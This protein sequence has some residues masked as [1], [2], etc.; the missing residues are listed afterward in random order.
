MSGKQRIIVIGWDGAT[1]DYIDP[2]LAIGD[3]PHL[4]GL[5]ERGARAT[6]RSTVPPFTNVA[7]PALVTGRRPDHTGIFG[8]ARRKAGSYERLPTNLMEY[9]GVP[10]WH[11]L[12]R[13]GYRAGVLNVPMTYPAAALDGYLVSGFDSPTET[14]D[15]ASPPT[16]FDRW[17]NDGHPYTVLH[18]EI[19]LMDSQNPHQQ[20]GNLEEFVSNWERLTEEQ[21]EFVAWVWEND[22]VDMLFVV[23]SGTD[24]INHRTRDMAHIRRIYRAA[25][26]ALGRILATV[27]DDTGVCLVSDHGSTPAHRYIALYRIL[28]NAGWLS[29]NPWIATRHL[30]RL[31]APLR[32]VVPQL[33]QYL[34]E[35]VRQLLSWPLLRIEP[36]LRETYSNIDWRRTTVYARSGMGPMYL[37]LQGREPTGT[38]APAAYEE[39]RTA[40]SDWLLNLRDA[41]GRPLFADV[42]RR[43]DVYPDADPEDEPPDLVF[44]PARWSDHVI[45]GYSTDPVVRDIPDE[46]E[47]GTHTPEGIFVLSGP[48]VPA[49]RMLE[50]AD[51]TDVMPTLLAHLGLPIPDS[52]DGTPQEGAFTTMPAL[53]Y[54]DARQSIS[55]GAVQMEA[56]TEVLERLRALGYL[57]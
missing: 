49:G 11:W 46:R 56:S 48:N 3:L 35:P 22:P 29:F 1:W 55:E 4:A 19:A 40:V 31:P 5:L 25:D 26:R 54:L 50:A 44:E 47:Y 52:V 15:V 9:R 33:W 6:L 16:L 21:G 45:T 30:R 51:I 23:F 13:F 34:P 43:E 12:N 7:W 53:T 38:V 36:R 27:D 24:S 39:M 18:K 2:M 17:A 42:M 20:R 14:A 32:S 10:V 8:G 41:D 28:H 57:D 37:N